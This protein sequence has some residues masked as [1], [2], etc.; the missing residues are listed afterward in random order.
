MHLEGN[1]QRARSLE[2]AQPP[3][4]ERVQAAERT[5]RSLERALSRMGSYGACSR[6][7]ALRRGF[8]F[9]RFQ[10]RR[11]NEA[12]FWLTG[13]PSRGRLTKLAGSPES[14]GGYVRVGQPR[15]GLGSEHAPW[16]ARSTPTLA[17]AP[18]GATLSDSRA[19]WLT[20][21]VRMTAGL[22]S[23]A[24]PLDVESLR[25]NH[26]RYAC[27]LEGCRDNHPRRTWFCSVR[28]GCFAVDF[29][30]AVPKNMGRACARRRRARSVFGGRGS[31]RG[32]VRPRHGSCGAA[33]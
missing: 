16:R 21:P 14:V 24:F 33:H 19:L 7:S 10:R 3:R 25:Y 22:L 28:T 11:G 6:S 29:C 26:R 17:L 2:E 23:G 5:G 27:L 15:P 8:L 31:K 9:S 13:R 18:P 20:T 4:G 32:E 1:A 12:T 30:L